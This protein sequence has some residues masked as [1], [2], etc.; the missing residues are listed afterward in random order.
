[1]SGYSGK[2]S[3]QLLTE[4]EEES[5]QWSLWVLWWLYLLFASKCNVKH[6]HLCAE[7][8]VVVHTA[9]HKTRQSKDHFIHD[10]DHITVPW[11]VRSQRFDAS[12]KRFHHRRISTIWSAWVVITDEMRRKGADPDQHYFHARTQHKLLTAEITVFLPVD[13]YSTP[14][15]CAWWP[16]FRW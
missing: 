11:Q 7:N 16:H 4:R 15:H 10:H 1:M 13:M 12:P 3:V 8:K 14:L 2:D 5:R 9:Q 6:L